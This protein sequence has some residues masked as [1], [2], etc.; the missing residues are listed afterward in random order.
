MRRLNEKADSDLVQAVLDH[1]KFLEDEVRI[2]KSQHVRR[3]PFRPKRPPC[4]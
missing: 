4:H 2:W 3:L 1:F